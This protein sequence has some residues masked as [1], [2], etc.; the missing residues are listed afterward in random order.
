[1]NNQ[2]QTKESMTEEEI[3]AKLKKGKSVQ[4][5]DVLLRSIL[6]KLPDASSRKNIASPYT[7]FV[8]IISNYRRSAFASALV[9]MLIIIGGVTYKLNQN[10]NNSTNQTPATVAYNNN[11]PSDN[12]VSGDS[13]VSPKNTTNII[14]PKDTSDAALSQDL[15]A[16]DAQL[17]GLNSDNANADNGLNNQNM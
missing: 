4:P 15:G 14:S 13:N 1:M 9:L 17:N 8:L 16:I 5:P 10:N 11:A 2:N 7:S 12:N 3:I 6:N